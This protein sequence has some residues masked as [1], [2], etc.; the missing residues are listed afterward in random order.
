[1]KSRAT[2]NEGLSQSS[3]VQENL[4]VE[5]KFVANDEDTKMQQETEFMQDTINQRNQDIN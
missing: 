1:M 5:S 2:L 3:F 4:L